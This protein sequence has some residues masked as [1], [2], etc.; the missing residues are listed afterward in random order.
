MKY[1]IHSHSG[2][3]GEDVFNN[4]QHLLLYTQ[5]DARLEVGCAG[6]SFLHTNWY[7]EETRVIV[8]INQQQQSGREILHIYFKNKKILTRR[9]K[10][11]VECTQDRTERWRIKGPMMT[12]V[13]YRTTPGPDRT[14]RGA[15][16]GKQ[17]NRQ[18]LVLSAEQP[19]SSCL[20]PS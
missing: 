4:V 17:H 3:P 19:R 18:G 16:G 9:L 8:N 12:S 7:E 14:T 5:T 11:P 13:N 2:S 1:T 6:R 20:F 15:D 10:L